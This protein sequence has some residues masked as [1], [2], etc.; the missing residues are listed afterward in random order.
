[1]KNLQSKELKSLTGGI[2]WYPGYNSEDHQRA[3]ELLIG[4]TAGVV[5]GF[6]D[7]LWDTLVEYSK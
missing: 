3:N 7:G 1:M 5:Y 4:T 6:F 2:G